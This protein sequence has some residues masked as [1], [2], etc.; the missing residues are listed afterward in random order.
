MEFQLSGH[1]QLYGSQLRSVWFWTRFKYYSIGWRRGRDR[2]TE[3]RRRRQ[4]EKERERLTGSFVCC[5]VL[6]SAMHNVLTLIAQST[7]EIVNRWVWEV[8]LLVCL[9]IWFL[10]ISRL[11]C[12]SL[13][14]ES[15]L[16]QCCYVW[17]SLDGMGEWVNKPLIDLPSPLSLSLS[18][19]L[20]PSITRTC[21]HT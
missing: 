20:P 7:D 9:R 6:N 13:L 4:R 16:D 21:K 12:R 15:S 3:W 14:V 8:C 10:Y 2:E 5:F 19:S 1:R 18:L 11:F 17:E